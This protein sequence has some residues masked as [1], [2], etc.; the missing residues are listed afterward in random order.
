MNDYFDVTN[1]ISYEKR[2]K[3]LRKLG[4]HEFP[5]DYDQ[6]VSFDH[7]IEIT[8][9]MIDEEIEHE[10]DKSTVEVETEDE[11]QQKISNFDA[12]KNLRNL[13]NFCMQHE[14]IPN[15]FFITLNEIEGY[16]NNNK[17]LRLVHFFL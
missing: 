9:F 14:N 17:D 2:F 15:P 11:F 12:T 7:G 6:F 16:I 1:M 13:R 8:A 3:H 4:T 10:F 5:E